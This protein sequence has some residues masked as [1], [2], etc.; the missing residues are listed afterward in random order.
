M[1]LVD[2]LHQL[3]YLKQFSGC[4]LLLVSL[5]RTMK[6]VTPSVPRTTY[7]CYQC[8]WNPLPDALNLQAAAA[9]TKLKNEIL[10]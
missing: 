5:L 10:I 7:F 2:A 8:T 6:C 1:L 9:V 3:K 4:K